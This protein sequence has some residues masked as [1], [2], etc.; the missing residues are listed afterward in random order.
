[1]KP[2]PF[3]TIIFREKYCLYSN[4]ILQKHATLFCKKT[5]DNSDDKYLPRNYTEQCF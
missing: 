3:I 1:M 2:G 5:I 4:N